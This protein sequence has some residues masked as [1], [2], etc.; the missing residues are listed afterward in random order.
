MKKIF[1]LLYIFLFFSI[2]L[3]SGDISLSASID[4]NEISM[5]DQIY[6][7]LT[8]NGSLNAPKPKIPEVEGL[9]I[10]SAGSSSSI[11][12]INGKVES[13][14]KLTYVVTPDREGSFRIP[15]AEIVNNGQKYFSNS[16][17][18]KVLKQSI[19]NNPQKNISQNSNNYQTVSNNYSSRNIRN[20]FV[21]NFLDKKSVYI[22]EPLILTF[23]LYTRVN[24]L[25]QPIFT[26]STT[27]SFWKEDLPVDKEYEDFYDNFKYH[28]VEKKVVLY[29]TSEGIQSI[30]PATLDCTVEEPIDE[31]NFWGSSFFSRGKELK[32]K[33]DILKVNVKPLP[34][35]NI[36]KDF[37]GTV[38]DYNMDVKIISEGQY[39][40]GEPITFD[41]AISGRGNINIITA[42]KLENTQNFK[43]Y[44]PV[45]KIDVKKDEYGLKGSKHFKIM[46]VPLVQGKQELPVVKYSFFNFKTEKYIEIEKRFDEINFEFNKDFND[47]SSL[48]SGTSV[49]NKNNNNLKIINGDIRFI[50]QKTTLKIKQTETD[51]YNSLYFWLFFLFPMLVFFIIEIFKYIRNNSINFSST[52]VFGNKKIANL[53]NKKVIKLN[54]KIA[55]DKNK[56][57]DNSFFVDELF[58]IFF[59]FLVFKFNLEELDLKK[60]KNKKNS[61][62]MSEVKNKMQEKNCTLE[63]Q[64]DIENFWNELDYYR[65]TNTKINTEDF[66]NLVKIFDNLIK[67]SL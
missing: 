16:I 22:N 50:K 23:K 33:T 44:D 37:S 3:F 29:P 4:R 11:S 34:N 60:I 13:Y 46:V 58:N 53:I 27:N 20:I 66:I 62:S 56:N 31:D 55:T 67:K 38:G 40:V 24:F 17:S 14:L 12:I 65:F 2:N 61:I 41:I 5:G 39:K 63:I 48:Q 28:I 32:L 15:P 30:A 9:S 21:K 6:Y 26:P 54:K 10:Y 42:P 47:G 1:F 35:R 8:I 7:S 18:F 45:E 59:E 19:N 57:Q 36:P 49:L 64:N 51:F 43:V 52:K 25:S